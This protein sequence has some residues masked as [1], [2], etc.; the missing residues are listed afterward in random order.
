MKPWTMITFPKDRPIY[1]RQ[2]RNLAG[3]ASLVTS[4]APAGVN[5][6]LSPKGKGD[7]VMHGITWIELFLGCEQILANGKTG[8]CGTEK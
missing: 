5:V 8:P 1:I 2:K 6:V 7:A 4:F 3:G